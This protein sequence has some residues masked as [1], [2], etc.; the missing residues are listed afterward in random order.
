MKSPI[1]KSF[2]KSSDE[3]K[4]EFDV[5]IDTVYCLLKHEESYADYPKLLELQKKNNV[6]ELVNKWIKSAYAISDAHAVFGY[7]VE[8]YQ[9]EEL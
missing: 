2:V 5:K 7:F 3:D 6:P 4:A 8:K 1:A 9:I